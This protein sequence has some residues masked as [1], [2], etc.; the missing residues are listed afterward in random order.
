MLVS[1]DGEYWG[2]IWGGVAGRGPLYTY[3]IYLGYIY[4]IFTSLRGGLGVRCI[5]AEFIGCFKGDRVLVWSRGC[6]VKRHDG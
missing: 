2:T 5:A 3:Y 1:V 4:S 6:D